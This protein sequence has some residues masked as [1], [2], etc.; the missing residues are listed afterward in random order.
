MSTNDEKIYQEL[1]NSSYSIVSI[2]VHTDYTFKFIT[3]EVLFKNLYDTITF[4]EEIFKKLDINLKL[5][6]NVIILSICISSSI[7]QNKEFEK[8]NYPK[9]TSH[10]KIII[11]NLNYPN[12]SQNPI[13]NL[14]N[15]P[16]SLLELI[17]ISPVSFNLNNLPNKLI[18]LDL[19]CSICKFNLDWLPSSIQILQLSG[20]PKN[21]YTIEELSN[22]P[23]SIEQIIVGKY[24]YSLDTL[25]KTYQFT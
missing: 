18:K 3:L 8:I 9:N 7:N 24:C 5:N 2:D 23:S 19:S 14:N 20:L 15:L 6:S 25:M 12:L 21:K 4:T 1:V 10:I 11:D 17:I 13:I 16:E 22:L